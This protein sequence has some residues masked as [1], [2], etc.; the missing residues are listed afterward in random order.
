[1]QSVLC[2][3]LR[4]I[5]LSAVGCLANLTVLMLVALAWADRYD[6][7]NSAAAVE[8]GALIAL[9]LLPSARRRPPL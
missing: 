8:D 2:E 4:I 7:S 5:A 9:V 6:P 3:G 1:M